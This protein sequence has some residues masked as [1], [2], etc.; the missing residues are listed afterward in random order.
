MALVRNAMEH[1]GY[2]DVPPP[3]V[4]VEPEDLRKLM[5][6]SIPKVRQIQIPPR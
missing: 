4:K 3:E 5:V 1:E 6:H 2:V